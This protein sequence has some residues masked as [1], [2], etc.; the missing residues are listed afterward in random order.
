MLHSS[1]GIQFLE[2]KQY[3]MPLNPNCSLKDIQTAQQLSQ[4]STP[5]QAAAADS[6]AALSQPGTAPFDQYTTTA[7]I[8]VCMSL[9]S[10]M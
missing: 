5:L 2:L 1:K 10:V 6:A 9:H 8:A 7:V 3:A 4:H